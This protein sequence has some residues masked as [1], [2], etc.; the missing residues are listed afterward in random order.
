MGD[1]NQDAEVT[2][3]NI[4]CRILRAGRRVIIRSG[5][6]KDVLNSEHF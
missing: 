1:I 4:H 3:V 5:G 6:M 2:W